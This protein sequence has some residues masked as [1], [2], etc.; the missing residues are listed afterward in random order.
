[1]ATTATPALLPELARDALVAS[2][3]SPELGD[4]CADVDR[5]RCVEEAIVALCQGLARAEV[6]SE[7]L[8]ATLCAQCS[9]S[10]SAA[11]RGLVAAASPLAADRADPSTLLDR[12]PLPS[13]RAWLLA[14]PSPLPAPAAPPSLRELARVAMAPRAATGSADTAHACANPPLPRDCV[15]RYRDFCALALPR[16]PKHGA[17]RR[18][19]VAAEPALGGD[20]AVFAT[21]A[22][23]LRRL[24]L[25]EVDSLRRLQPLRKAVDALALPTGE[26]ALRLGGGGCTVTVRTL[27]ELLTERYAALAPDVVAPLF[28]R[29]DVDSQG[30][31]GAVEVE[32]ASASVPE[33][34]PAN[35]ED[36]RQLALD[37]SGRSSA[38]S[39]EAADGEA[40]RLL[41]DSLLRLG[42]LDVAVDA[43]R[44]KLL[45]TLEATSGVSRGLAAAFRYLDRGA[46][47][48]VGPTDVWQ[49]LRRAEVQSPPL[50]D[51]RVLFRDIDAQL[52]LDAASEHGTRLNF[53]LICALLLPRGS[54]LATAAQKAAAEGGEASLRSELSLREQTSCCQGC[55]A[56]LQRS[57]LALSA[58][59]AVCPV[60]GTP[61]RCRASDRNRSVHEGGLWGEEPVLAP[62]AEIAL[63]HLL[64]AATEAAAEAAK[65][66][67]QLQRSPVF[68]GQAPEV[69]VAAALGLAPSVSHASDPALVLRRED[70]YRL[71]RACGVW[72]PEAELSLDL[73]WRRLTAGRSGGDDHA[74][75]PLRAL[76]AVLLPA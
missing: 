42:D 9:F 33:T 30:C 36:T 45:C 76:A 37:E 59:S 12:L 71:F 70:L 34:K 3:K 53:C 6:A 20:A 35:A 15:I 47:G 18:A 7:E 50:E 57:S 67:V 38:R 17:L 41:L 52:G 65:V 51:I 40:L 60:C 21:A 55:G 29:I 68:V 61:S 75:V 49:L 16:D 26:L 44:S 62:R 43:R 39:R 63:L 31:A 4:T 11:F 22:N 23:A 74:P 46:K 14:E 72:H 56:L 1:M 54:A 66:R 2:Q 8:R 24:L 10:P 13:L 64:E 48:F 58:I 27:R 25:A 32:Y 73:L 19:V 28:R 69:A 5:E